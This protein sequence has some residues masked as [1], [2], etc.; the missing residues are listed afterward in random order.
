MLLWK[1]GN[2]IYNLDEKSVR[3]AE[4]LSRI[5]A[6]KG[7]TLNQLSA[8]TKISK[9]TLSNILNGV[10]SPYLDTII[11]ICNYLE[12][13]L[14][15]LAGLGQGGSTVIVESELSEVEQRIIYVYRHLPP[16][17]AAWMDVAVQMLERYLS[18]Y[19]T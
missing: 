11:R 2:M 10:S 1:V 13:S 3:L 17:K 19:E 6:A 7:I 8:A 4:N 16:E 18:I 9:S 14:E 12:V 5:C 15:E